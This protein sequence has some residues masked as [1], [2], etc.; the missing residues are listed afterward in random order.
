MTELE[1]AVA[2]ARG[3][4]GRMLPSPEQAESE[5]AVALLQYAQRIEKE[6]MEEFEIVNEKLLPLE[7]R[8]VTVI[9]S[10]R[11]WVDLCWLMEKLMPVIELLKPGFVNHW[12]QPFPKSIEDFEKPGW[13][14]FSID[15]DKIA[16]ALKAGVAVPGVRIEEADDAGLKESGG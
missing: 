5:Q 4:P 16:S 10:G 12:L 11:I 14:R 15:K 2:Y 6:P 13:P 7:Y 1:L 3:V 8:T 9:F